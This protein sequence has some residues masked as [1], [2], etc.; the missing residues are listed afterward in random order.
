MAHVTGIELGPNYCVLV[1]TGRGASRAIVAGAR[2]VTPGEWSGDPNVLADVL[3]QAR[4]TNQLPRRARVVAW[5]PRSSEAIAQR[6]E[7]SALLSAGFQIGTVLSPAQALAGVVRARQL[8]DRDATAALSLNTHGAAMA[9]ISGEN[10]LWSRCFEWPLGKPF[11]RARSEFLEKYLIISQLAPQLQHLIDLVRP[12]F[13][14]EVTSAIACGNLPNL[15]SLMMLLIE[16]MDLEVETLDSADLLEPR[17]A[18]GMCGDSAA[19]LQLAS[20]AA[21]F[22]EKAV[23][24]NQVAGRAAFRISR[25][26][27]SVVCATQPLLVP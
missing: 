7:V 3:R 19:A 17:A 23:P 4:R 8:D 16:E 15:R 9:I 21:A 6:P 5:G 14:V 13:G 18:A 26:R 24:P 11:V 22:D 27:R 25:L 12:V 20:A 10:I 2:A 1:R